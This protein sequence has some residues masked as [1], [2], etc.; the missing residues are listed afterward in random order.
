MVSESQG[1]GAV[2][3]RFSSEDSS[4]MGEVTGEPRVARHSWSCHLS[5]APRLADQIAASRKDS[6]RESGCPGGK[7]RQI[8]SAFFLIF[9]L[10]SRACLA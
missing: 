2:F 8:F 5:N 4:Q 3:L 9:H 1:A 10:C 6:A 7:T